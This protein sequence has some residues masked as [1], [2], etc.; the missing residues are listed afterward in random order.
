MVFTDW[1]IL[2]GTNEIGPSYL[3]TLGNAPAATDPKLYSEGYAGPS[4]ST[5]N[6]INVLGYNE[7]LVE[8]WQW[9]DSGTAQPAANIRLKYLAP[10]TNYYEFSWFKVGSDLNLWFSKALNGSGSTFFSTSTVD[11]PP[12]TGQWFGVRCQ[13]RW[14]D[15]AHTLYEFKVWG[16][17][18]DN[19]GWRQVSPDGGVI[20]NGSILG[21]LPDR[22]DYKFA[23]GGATWKRFDN[24]RISPVPFPPL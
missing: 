16:N 5:I 3:S 6:G 24:F 1:G 14:Q 18:N 23:L 13:F 10:S 15:D 19:S 12:P 2:S 7:G 11:F 4:G 21:L 8:W 9:I 22:T 17:L 20:D